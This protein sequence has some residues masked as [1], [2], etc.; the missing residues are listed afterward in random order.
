MKI[1]I[2]DDDAFFRGLYETLLTP[3]GYECVL[4]TSG[5]EAIALAEGPDAPRLLL[6]DWVMPGGDG[7]DVCRHLRAAGGP[8]RYIIMVSAR[9]RA[10]DLLAG[11]QAGADDFLTKPFVAEEL[12]ARVRAA[13]R[14][15]RMGSEAPS[16]GGALAEALASDG[17]DVI[18][19]QGDAVARILVHSGRIAWIHVSTTSG[20]LYDVLG[21][22]E[23]ISRDE[24]REVLEECA[25]TGSSFGAVITEW[26]LL[27]RDELRAVIRRWLSAR[28]EE[29]LRMVPEVVL[30][31]PERRGFASDLLFALDELIS[32]GLSSCASSS[33]LSLSWGPVELTARLE[34]GD[35]RWDDALL[36]ALAIDGAVTAAVV[37]TRGGVVVARRG[38]PL[39]RDLV[40][41][42]AKHMRT[43]LDPHGI[44]DMIVTTREAY[45]HLHLLGSSSR[46]LLYVALDRGLANLAITRHALV[47][48][49][50]ALQDITDAAVAS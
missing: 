35:K 16:I 22:V 6:L 49:T 7:L 44:E 17:G 12:Y 45:H 47:K 50:S 48:I 33:S 32:G 43:G 21:E 15:L 23:S 14:L 37:E 38:D 27:T 9:G 20:T 25:A 13:E 28:L 8:Y 10:R 24:I 42:L 26:G 5:E 4:A 19:R 41:P 34:G 18:I 2:A 36:R 30:F 40:F 3:L 29:V 11:F 39:D 46:F 1:L 31:S